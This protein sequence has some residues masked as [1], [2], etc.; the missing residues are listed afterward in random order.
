[1]VDASSP[2]D[3]E[4]ALLKMIIT[5]LSLTFTDSLVLS[6]LAVIFALAV[7]P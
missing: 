3:Y 5:L 4:E 1:M 2:M 6:D 7:N